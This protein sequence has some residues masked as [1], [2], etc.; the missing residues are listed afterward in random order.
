MRRPERARETAA[1]PASA[2]PGPATVGDDRF[3]AIRSVAIRLVAIRSVVIRFKPVVRAGG[4][5]GAR[6]GAGGVASRRPRGRVARRG[7]GGT[8]RVDGPIT[9]GSPIAGEWS[10][11]DE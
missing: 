7:Q 4:R 9:G 3:V 5:P 10:G 1:S 6:L 11:S 8:L 2:P